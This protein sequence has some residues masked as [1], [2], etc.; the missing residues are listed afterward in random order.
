M[1]RTPDWDLLAFLRRTAFRGGHGSISPA[2]RSCE[3]GG[4][5]EVGFG[6]APV[7]ES[8]SQLDRARSR[9]KAGE[10]R[11]R[12]R[13]PRLVIHVRELR[14]FRREAVHA[15]EVADADL[16]LPL[17]RCAQNGSAVE[18]GGG[19]PGKMS[20]EALEARASR[21]FGYQSGESDRYCDS[22][23]AA[24]WV[25]RAAGGGREDR[26]FL[27]NA[28]GRGNCLR[29]AAHSAGSSRGRG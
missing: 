18:T 15:A 25:V 9:V 22:A 26:R 28:V 29:R 14:L 19:V 20:G 12:R 1:T 6:G 5:G 21:R 17:G 27:R 24:V 4:G 23:G 3:E 13:R 16:E 10:G 2:C 8:Q 7:L 11:W